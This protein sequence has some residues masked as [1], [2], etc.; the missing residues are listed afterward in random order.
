[1][2]NL[3]RTALMVLI[4]SGTVST[5]AQV[6]NLNSYS[7]A[8]P[9]IYLDFD[10]HYVEGTMWNVYGPFN[11]NS[12]GL[13]NTQITEVFNRVA[14]DFRP[15]NINV[16]T[17]ETKYN[18]APTNRRVRIVI[19]TSNEWYGTGAGGVAYL[20]SFTWSDETPAFVFSALFGYNIKKI[21]EASSHETGHT[22]GLRHQSS[23]D[24][25]CVKISDY[26]WGYGVGEIGWAP[27]MG[28]GYN[29][30]MTLWHNGPN[31]ISCNNIQTDLSIITSITNGLGFRTDDHT[32]AFATATT[33]NFNS[34]QQFTI[35]GV[36]EKT[37]DKDLFKFTMPVA[38]N[39][40]LSAVPYNVG[41]GNSGSDLDLQVEFID[42]S[43]NTLGIYNP[44]TTLSSIVD[45]IIDAGIYYL[46]IDGKGNIY[47][48]EYGSL[49]SF[50][51]LGAYTPGTSLPVHRLELKGQLDRES[52][53]LSWIIDA[54][55]KVISQVIEYSFDGRTF[56]PLFQPDDDIRNYSYRPAENRPVQYR[57]HVTFDNYR[58]YYSN[59]ITI[60]QGTIIK[61][62]L[63][64][65]LVNSTN[66][67]V[68]SPAEYDYRVT[69]QSGRIVN[70]GKITKGFS[71]LNLGTVMQGMY[72]ITFT[73]G[74]EQ[75]T[76]KIVKQ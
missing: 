13:D 32:D 55:E 64:G 56:I 74:N 57:L 24:A 26:H 73:N 40:E 46:R 38:G 45:T 63:I 48:P 1:M 14:E 67:S 33:T 20:N 7:S 30:N 6:P 15:F 43:Y 29:Q 19:T 4:A 41:T 42:A 52:H 51:L 68:K 37:D 34:N 8:N 23:Y 2:K 5:K 18:Q 12:S 3:I 61:P 69:D 10:G 54:D 49:G 25:N 65:N 27:I 47:A 28:A 53:L 16:T 75:W 36:V 58:E 9:V 62:Q 17:S 50:S 11:C 66:V 76:E 31:S 70:K 59:V 60:R 39:F 71:S 35:S 21:S 72:M 44:G 22:L